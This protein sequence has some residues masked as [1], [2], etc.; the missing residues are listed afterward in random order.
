MLI[1]LVS[2]GETFKQVEKFSGQSP[3]N[4][5]RENGVRISDQRW[6][7]SDLLRNLRGNHL[8]IAE[9]NNESDSP[10][11]VPVMKKWREI[12]RNTCAEDGGE[13]AMHAAPYK[14]LSSE[15]PLS[16][17]TFH[18]KREFISTGGG[19]TRAKWSSI[20]KF[21]TY[22]YMDVFLEFLCMN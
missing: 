14:V 9:L 18:F 19:N 2:N 10:I 13:K 21:E 6:K 11:Y 7:R 20:T 8:R 3:A 1:G 16:I 4:R 22:P 12:L 17:Y 5:D 15:I